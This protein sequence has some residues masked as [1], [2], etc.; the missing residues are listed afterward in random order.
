MSGRTH[1]CAHTY[2][3]T[4]TPTS[5]CALT[6]SV[7]CFTVLIK[8]AA[9]ISG[10]QHLT[11]DGNGVLWVRGNPM[12]QPQIRDASTSSN[13]ETSP[14]NLRR[15]H[16]QSPLL[17]PSSI[18]RAGLSSTQ[19]QMHIIHRGS[20]HTESSNVFTLSDV[21]LFPLLLLFF[22]PHHCLFFSSFSLS[23]NKCTKG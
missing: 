6:Q 15:H 11:E 20:L 9:F 4:H 8:A 16:T 7:G 12:P 18:W 10:L 21:H 17:R 14:R 5:T 19:S 13:R 23:A 2:I 22:P 3:H 1:E